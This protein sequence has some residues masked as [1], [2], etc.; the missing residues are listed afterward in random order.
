MH[1]VWPRHGAGQEEILTVG[2]GSYRIA[3]AMTGGARGQTNDIVIIDELREM[4]S[5]DIIAAAEPT[6]LTSG[7]PQMIYLSNAG[8]EDSVVLNGVRDRAGKDESL[9]YLEWSA[10]P[11]RPADDREGWLEANPSYGHIPSVAEGLERRYRRYSLSGNMAKFETEHL[12]RWVVSMRQ[13]LVGEAA[14]KLCEAEQETHPTR[15]FMGVSMDP[16]GKRV[17]A[18][19]AWLDVD[20]RVAMEHVYEATGD[21]VPTADAGA[22]LKAIAQRARVVRVGFDPMTDAE[23][24]KYFPRT[25]SVTASKFAN[26]TSTFVN[27]VDSQRLRHAESD[28]VADDLT[29]TARKEHEATGKFIAVRANDDRPITAALAAIRAVW[30]A[31]DLQPPIPKVY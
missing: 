12:C 29:W 30:L 8:T 15:P 28:Q 3:A 16:D 9:A 7:D 1:T 14:W 6:M 31:S 20:G 11:N 18:V 2:G 27:R 4:E 22:D 10:A 17:S 23:L 13:R 24:A 21:P 26:A 5:D 19:L 25:E